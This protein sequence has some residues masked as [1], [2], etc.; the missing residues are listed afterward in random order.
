V[1]KLELE[2]GTDVLLLE[3]G[4]ALLLESS[5]AIIIQIMHHLKQLANE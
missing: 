3:S 5:V 2:S 1:A 4:D